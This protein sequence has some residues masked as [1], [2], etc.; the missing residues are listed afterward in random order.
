MDGALVDRRG[1][2]QPQKRTRRDYDEVTATRATFVTTAR[3]RPSDQVAFA[4]G[5][6]LDYNRA[7][8]R[9]SNGLGGAGDMLPYGAGELGMNGARG[10]GLDGP[11]M[12]MSMGMG[13]MGGLADDGL[14]GPSM[15][16]AGLRGM[17]IDMGMGQRVTALNGISLEHESALGLRGGLAMDPG[18]PENAS[19]TLYV[20]GVPA[21]CS[22]REA[23]HIF[24]PFIGFQGLRLVHRESKRESGDKIVLC[25]VEFVN[26][27]C[28]ATAMDA[29]QGYKFDEAE[30][31]DSHVL[32]LDFARHAGPRSAAERRR[33]DDRG[34][35]GSSRR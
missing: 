6:D 15:R 19:A 7:G 18:L 34:P 14:M 24:R 9:G 5:A 11:G 16:D 10:M 1:V 31:G 13:V 33:S 26:P 20:E 32:R 21:D 29:L 2:V 17:G 30:A 12:G 8:Y 25:F 4:R 28:A 22:K 27:Q 3:G 35:R 23:A